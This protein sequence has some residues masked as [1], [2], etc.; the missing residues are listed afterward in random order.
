MKHNSAYIPSFDGIRSF[1]L[2]AVLFYHLIPSV[3]KGGYLGVVIFFVLAGFLSMQRVMQTGYMAEGRLPLAGKAFGKKLLKLYPA[4]LL[5]ISCVSLVIFLFFP[6]QLAGVESDIKG[7]VFS[8]NNYSQILSGGSYFE[9]SGA[10]KPFTH[11]WALSLEVQVYLLIYTFLYGRYKKERSFRMFLFLILL[12]LLSYGISLVL[13]ELGYDFTRVY[14]GIATR[15]Y[16][17]SLGAAASFFAAGNMDS[18]GLLSRSA[19]SACI[20]ALC[21]LLTASV[22]VFKAE[23]FV[24]YFGFFAYSIL[25]AILLVLLHSEHSAFYKALSAKPFS[26]LTARSYHIYLWHFPIIALQDRFFANRE[27]SKAGYYL[28]F[29]LLCAVLSELSYRV[30]TIAGSSTRARRSFLPLAL[31]L[32]VTLLFVPY[33]KISANTAESRAL[34]QM[35]EQILQNEERQK[36]ERAVQR[37]EALKEKKRAFVEGRKAKATGQSGAEQ[38]SEAQNQEKSPLLLLAL[39]H[40]EWVN[41]LQDAFLYLDPAEYEKYKDVEG[42]LIGDSIASMSYHT[43]AT[44]LPNFQF[45]SEHSREMATAHEAFQKYKNEDFGDYLILALGSNGETKHED[46]E[47]IRKELNGKKLI[48]LSIVLPYKEEEESRNKKIRS[49]AKA[50]EDVY[51]VDWYRAAKNRPEL[52]FDDKIHPGEDGAKV[53]GQ[54]LSKQ[55]IELEKSKKRGAR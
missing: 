33:Q 25:S 48:L 4:L 47:K 3:F 23:R 41:G 45:D 7:A 20:A 17:F 53:L 43:L 38:A 16:S 40:I 44:Y 46:I 18:Q 29:F 28:I 5:M 10:L 51:L 34:S 54:I 42:L 14:Y 52:F 12:S 15:L 36:I 35:K 30:T 9:S 27:I 6:S 24:F 1:A 22:F 31:C 39:S 49:Y 37:K 50:H 21:I 26:F 2:L 8:V 19:R 11:I 13:L 32:S 55:L